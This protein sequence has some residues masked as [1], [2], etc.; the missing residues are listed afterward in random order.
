MLFCLGRL[1]AWPSSSSRWQARSVLSPLHHAHLSAKLSFQAQRNWDFSGGGVRVA[2]MSVEERFNTLHLLGQANPH[3][4]TGAFH[5]GARQLGLDVGPPTFQQDALLQGGLV[6]VL[7][8]VLLWKAST[9]G[10]QSQ[11]LPSLWMCAFRRQ[12]AMRAEWTKRKPRR[13][14]E[15]HVVAWS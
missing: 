9:R 1:C 5:F 2:R 3:K 15:S 10:P 4:V 8:S 11:C 14:S 7:H 12:G 6:A 13:S